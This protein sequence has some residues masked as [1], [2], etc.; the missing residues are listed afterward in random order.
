MKGLANKEFKYIQPTESGIYVDGE[1]RD[2][3]FING[4]NKIMLVARNNA[5]ILA[6]KRK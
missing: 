5:S 4:K 2:V 3:T 6:F 1:V